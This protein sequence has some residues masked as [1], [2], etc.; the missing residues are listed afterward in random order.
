MNQAKARADEVFAALAS[1]EIKFDEA[2]V[3]HG[4]FFVND[5]KRGR[6]GFLPLN[7]LKQQLRESEY[8]QLLDANR[9]FAMRKATSVDEIYPVFRDLFKKEGALAA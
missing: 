4:E 6:L 9:H 8:T 5:D 1:K 3:K 7:Q 2:L